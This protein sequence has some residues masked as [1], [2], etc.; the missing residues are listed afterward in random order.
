MKNTATETDPTVYGSPLQ[1]DENRIGA[2]AV[3][4]SDGRFGEIVNDFL[5]NALQLP[6]TTAWPCRAGR[7]AWPDIFLPPKKTR[8]PSNCDF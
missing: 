7:A 1:F 8:W 6:R 3:Y 2:A 5:H 4:C